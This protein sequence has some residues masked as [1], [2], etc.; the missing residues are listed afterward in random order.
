MSPEATPLLDTTYLL[1]FFGMEIR[2]E[3]VKHHLSQLLTSGRKLLFHPL[4][5]VEAK[6]VVLAIERKGKQGLRASFLEG[7][8]A[9]LA[10]K[11]FAPSPL[12]SKAVEANAD[13]LLDE[14]LQDYFDRMLASTAHSLQTIL[15]TEDEELLNPKGPLRILPGLRAMSIAVYIRKEAG[16]EP[17]YRGTAP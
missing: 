8:D 13:R 3:G 17:R 11:R 14:G 9:L 4:S 2:V 16:D 10:D 15:L 7:L 5:L 6:W 12:T 1:P